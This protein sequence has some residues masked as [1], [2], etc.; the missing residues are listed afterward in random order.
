MSARPPVFVVLACCAALAAA[1]P[2]AA[3]DNGT[4]SVPIVE[5]SGGY[6]F[7]RDTSIE[8]DYPRG[9]YGSVAWNMNQWLG[10][11]AEANGSYMS[12]DTTFDTMA[13]TVSDRDR[14][15]S[16]M[17]GTRF[18]HKTGRV[19]PFAQVLV[20]VAH[21][22]F[23]QTQTSMGQGGPIGSHTWSAPSTSAFALQPGAGVTVY[24]TEH[25]GVRASGDYRWMTDEDDESGRNAFRFLTGFTFHWGNR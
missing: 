8:H 3:Q 12:E 16:F 25:V 9:W 21:R 13:M 6:T 24:L 14:L 11:V 2:A 23:Q 7:L 22:R 10:L 19:A 17:G 4:L 20:G 1:A 5:I 15:Y 18:F